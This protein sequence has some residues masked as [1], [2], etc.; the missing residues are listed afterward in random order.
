MS[1]SDQEPWHGAIVVRHGSQHDPIRAGDEITTYELG[2]P[3][4]YLTWPPH[5]GR[6]PDVD[7]YADAVLGLAHDD[8]WRVQKSY[9]CDCR[10]RRSVAQLLV[11]VPTKRLWVSMKPERVPA[12]FRRGPSG[13]DGFPLHGVP[14][15]AP[16][17][18]GVT[19]CKGCDKRWLV[20]SF[21]DAVELFHVR[22][23]RHGA[24]I[25]P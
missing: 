13:V 21:P 20:V 18:N 12:A 24:R 4:P 11:H 10:Q 14:G 6:H 8:D 1:E 7:T 22:R 5:Q 3:F 23:A 16:H 2:E 9:Y 15:E 25:A 17:V 19:S